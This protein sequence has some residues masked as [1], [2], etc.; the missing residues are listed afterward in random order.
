MA[1]LEIRS[2]FLMMVVLVAFL[3]SGC[4]TVDVMKIP[5]KYG[6]EVSAD[7][8]ELNGYDSKTISDAIMKVNK[9]GGKRGIYEIEKISDSSYLIKAN[10]WISIY[11]S[12]AAA[13]QLV[14]YFVQKK[15]IQNIFKVTLN[16]QD[17]SVI[18][19]AE[20]GKVLITATGRPLDVSTYYLYY[21][22]TAI[23]PAALNTGSDY[24]EIN[25]GL[26]SPVEK[27][28]IQEDMQSCF[29]D[30]VLLLEKFLPKI[31]TD[32]GS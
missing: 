14:G 11:T 23:L 9:R 27:E 32:N 4:A 18:L 15:N 13:T 28:M 29:K 17:N 24:G 6:R 5:L 12:G 16:S 3:F 30:F 10:E 2:R 7:T 19:K 22:R 21:T 25:K 26:S 31:K 1:N 20:K 8:V